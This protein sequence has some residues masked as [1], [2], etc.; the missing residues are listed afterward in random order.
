MD[1]E[2]VSNYTYNEVLA[3]KEILSY[4]HSNPDEPWEHNALWNKI[5]K[6][7]TVWLHLWDIYRSQ[8]H[9]NK[10][11]WSFPGGL[12]GSEM[13][14]VL[15]SLSITRWK[16]PRDMLHNNVNTVNTTEL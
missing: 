8:N 12:K 7:N 5:N 15:W 1:K 6:A 2:N 14:V 4:V 3:L 13:V 11:E 9:R 16:I 10:V